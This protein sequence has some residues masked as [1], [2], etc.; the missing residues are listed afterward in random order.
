M[1]E[2]RPKEET[3]H[4][5]DEVTL[6]REAFIELLEKALSG[7]RIK[8]RRTKD[9]MQDFLVYITLGSGL[10]F[11]L[12]S[13]SIPSL[14]IPGMLGDFIFAEILCT[15]GVLLIYK[16]GSYYVRRSK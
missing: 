2:G 16:I 7:R 10:N 6:S 4:G 9:R 3:D 12:S 14:G 5:K 11:G 15:F 1:T 13:V 8:E